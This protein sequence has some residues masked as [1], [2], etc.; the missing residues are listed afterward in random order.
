MIPD[1]YALQQMKALQVAQNPAFKALVDARGTFEYKTNVY[2]TT[3]DYI[4]TDT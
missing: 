1:M 3:D 2:F 4:I